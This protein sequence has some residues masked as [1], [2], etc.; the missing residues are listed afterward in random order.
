MRATGRRVADD[1]GDADNGRRG[2]GA[3]PLDAGVRPVREQVAGGA[4]EAGQGG[5][6]VALQEGLRIPAP[7]RSDPTAGRNLYISSETCNI[8]PVWGDIYK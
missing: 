2:R 3:G 8:L 5:V 6:S 7:A 1:G 4:H